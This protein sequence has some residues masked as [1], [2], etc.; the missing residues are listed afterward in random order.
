MK[1]SCRILW[2]GISDPEHLLL[3]ALQLHGEY[4]IA[5]T[6]SMATKKQSN[7]LRYS[8]SSYRAITISPRKVLLLGSSDSVRL[9][10]N[11]L[12]TRR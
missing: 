6:C 9:G 8:Y 2:L 10:T 12:A 4:E 3:C 1:S 5:P 7:V 11:A